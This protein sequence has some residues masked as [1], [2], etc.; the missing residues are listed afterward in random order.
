MVTSAAFCWLQGNLSGGNLDFIFLLEEWKKIIGMYFKFAMIHHFWSHSTDHACNHMVTVNHEGRWEMQFVVEQSSKKR[1]QVQSLLAVFTTEAIQFFDQSR[2]S[3]EG[4]TEI[5]F[6]ELTHAVVENAVG[7][8]KPLVQFQCK[9]KG[10]GDRETDNTSPSSSIGEEQ[11][12]SS[13]SGTESEFF[14]TLSFSSLQTSNRLDDV[15]PYWGH[16]HLLL[17][18]LLIQMLLSSGSTLTDTPIKN[19]QPDI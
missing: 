19:V 4:E 14:L 3:R 9:P 8:G 7:P 18:S 16:G 13:N 10:Q 15:H 17:L 6:K 12:F 1:N 2:I 11:C 5:S